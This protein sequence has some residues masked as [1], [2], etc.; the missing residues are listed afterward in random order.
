MLEIG[1][2]RSREEWEQV[3][4]ICC[5]TGDA[6]KPVAAERWPFFAEFWIGPYQRLLPE[7]TFVA[8]SEGR[9]I[10]YLT[11]C[12]SSLPF[13][14]R[15]FLV[16]RLPLYA[17]VLLGRWGATEDTRRFLHPGEGVRRNMAFRFGA[18]LYATLLRRYPS[19]LHV[20]VRQGRREKGIGSRLMEA[21]IARLAERGVRGLH[22]FCGK[23]PVP[24]YEKVGFSRLAELDFGKGP[25]F[26]MVREWDLPA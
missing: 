7:W 24:F 10:G 20:N 18:K 11:G 22:L 25:V 4:E 19:H 17:A 9:V 26:A 14:A 6:G 16:H 13:Y 12:P 5:E 21:Y 3:R 15:R 2:V 1:P 8:R 23:G